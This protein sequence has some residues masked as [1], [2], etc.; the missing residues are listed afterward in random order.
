[1]K[2]DERFRRPERLLLWGLVVFTCSLPISRA[3]RT[4]TSQLFTSFGTATALGNGDFVSNS[5][6]FPGLNTY[7]SYFIEVPPGTSGL[8]VQYFDA[9]IGT[10]PS[11]DVQQ[12]GSWNTT[13]QYRLYDP[14]GTLI[15]TR[16]FGPGQCPAC[17]NSWRRMHF[18]N[19]PT[20]G[21]WELQVDMSSAV[22]LGD[23][24]NLFGI[25]AHDGSPGGAGVELNVYMESYDLIGVVGGG[26]N[27]TYQH[28]PYV[29]S[30]CECDSN[31]FDSDNNGSFAY[32]SRSGG[33]SQTV[34]TVSGGTSWANNIVSGW[35]TDFTAVDYGIWQAGLTMNAPLSQSGNIATL[36]LGAFNAANPPTGGSG[37]PPTA[38][39]EASTF[40]VYIPTDS[41]AAPVKPYVEQLLTYV[42]GPNPTQVG[43]TT[44]FSVTVR[45]VNPTVWPITFGGPANLVTTNVPGGGAVYAGNAQITQGTLTQPAVGGAGNVIWDP[46]IVTAGSTVVL[47]YE[48]DVTPSSAG[49]R[50]PVTGTPTSNGTTAL[51]VD[52]TGDTTQSRATTL[53]GPLCELAVTEGFIITHAVVSSFRALE[54]EGQVRVEWETASEAGT[55]GFYLFRFDPEGNQ[56]I[57]IQRELVPGLIHSPQGGHYSL[58]DTTAATHSNNL[59]Y[60]IIEMEANGRYRVHGPFEVRLGESSESS[61]FRARTL[62]RRARRPDRRLL[63]KLR[64]AH[65]NEK[66]TRDDRK[67]HRVGPRAQWVKMGVSEPGIYYVGA[68][69]I[70]AL[71]GLSSARARDQIRSRG[72]RIEHRAEPVAWKPDVG[73]RGLVFFGT[74]IDSPYTRE[75]VYWLSLGTGRRMESREAPPDGWPV[76]DTFR[77][78]LHFE[79]DRFAGTVASTDPDSDFWYWDYVQAGDPTLGTREFQLET[80]G[81]SPGRAAARITVR[82]QSATQTG[83]D[84]EHHIQVRVNGYQVGDSLWDG[85]KK[86][87]ASFSFPHVVLEPT[88]TIEIEGRL[89]AGVPYSFLYVDEIELAYERMFHADGSELCFRT[90][91][92]GTIS[93]DGF[94]EPA[95]LLFDV[96][97]PRRPVSIT[98]A[99]V[100]PDQLGYRT[101]FRAET[102]TA[103]YL[104]AT[105]AAAKAP[106]W[107]RRDTPSRLKQKSQRAD[108]LVIAPGVFEKEA[109]M[110]AE[111]RRS[112]GLRSR[113][114]LL[115]DVMDEFNGG[116]SD[117]HALRR[118]LQYAHRYWDGPPRFVVL[119]G[120][121]TFDYRDVQ[122]MGGNLVPP[123]MVR[124]DE[125]L[126]A[127]DSRYADLV[128]DDAVPELAVG[129]IPAITPEDLRAYLEKIKT[130]ESNPAENWHRRVLMA[131]DRWDTRANFRSD[132]RNLT[133]L[134]PPSFE[135]ETIYLDEL[136]L[137]TARAFFKAALDEGVAHVNYVGHGGL[138]RFSAD[139]LFT[140]SDVPELVNGDRLAVVTA[141]TCS[142][143]RFGIPG[144]NSLAEEWTG[145]EHGG[146]AAVWAPTGL[147]DH[148]QARILGESFFRERFQV[149]PQRIGEMILNALQAFSARGGT[150]SMLEIYQLFGDPALLVAPPPPAEALPGDGLPY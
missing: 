10:G 9:D 59:L 38:Q 26:N 74:G 145:R 123:L 92:E 18:Q 23:D 134:L 136:P 100:E 70:A 87:E 143:G 149:Q 6:S 54:E 85:R 25:R 21:H 3:G 96:T 61:A 52:E 138:D 116:I 105:R 60:A 58:F 104:A 124:T 64:R 111:Y 71:F 130:Y 75:N 27:L 94:N 19:L 91:R 76:H 79:E 125:G 50:V 72:L 133:S 11:H 86:H 47:A 16:T 81:A 114:V 55:A 131:A 135:A 66:R 43:Q 144:F 24:L 22:T 12:G 14:N 137:D 95:V 29:T 147:S 82:L 127:S 148:R 128:G 112:G 53:F 44:R 65:R 51:F 106:L 63:K 39:P 108:Y 103:Q 141:M 132:S 98:G 37:P 17:D 73:G 102:G 33:F 1:M 49:Q 42:S 121:G 28:Y 69:Q 118:F 46:G 129:R 57:P 126:F 68:D 117:P 45:V 30:G 90:E 140:T 150:R 97:D 15:R 32:T 36:Y 56:W 120:K 119:A 142:V 35:T 107:I 7:L 4:P 78:R 109:E 115:E 40:R 13:V 62:S 101:S 83:A 146:A 84:N 139:S 80:P 110:L 20:A 88:N 122:S 2:G 41:G 77:E 48:V 89:D 34:S 67:R 5:V 93:I 113:V 31:D 8:V 99:R